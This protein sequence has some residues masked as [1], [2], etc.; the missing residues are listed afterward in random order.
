MTA[1]A[2]ESVNI[3]DCAVNIAT[4]TALMWQAILSMANRNGGAFDPSTLVEGCTLRGSG[5]TVGVYI[6][7]GS[8]K[9]LSSNLFQY[10]DVNILSSFTIKNNISNSSGYIHYIIQPT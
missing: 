4:N 6:Y 10:A 9:H 3:R 1:N 2:S 8:N 5:Y 7:S